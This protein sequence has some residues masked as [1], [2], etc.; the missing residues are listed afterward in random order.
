MT[1]T[2][3]HVVLDAPDRQADWAAGVSF[4]AFLDAAEQYVDLWRGTFARLTVPDDLLARVSAIPGTWQLLVI[5]AD[6]CI[7]AISTVSAVA[8]LADAA[9]TLEL[10]TLDRDEHLDLMDE[11]LTDGRARSIPVIL[12]LDGEGQER[13]WWGPRP[14][15]LQRWFTA[16]GKAMPSEQRYRELRKWYARDRGVTTMREI[17]EMIETAAPASVG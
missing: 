16:E 1:D 15:D 7:D 10:R 8:R 9:P 12:L 5:S 17:V 14:A 4:E 13:G 2:T 6:W 11:H 3:T